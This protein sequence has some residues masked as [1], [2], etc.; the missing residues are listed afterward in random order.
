[1]SGPVRFLYKIVFRASG[2][3]ILGTLFV[4]QCIL[5][6]IVFRASGEAILGT[7]KY[8]SMHFTVKKFFAPPA[9]F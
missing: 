9:R 2:E 3:A 7:L 5:R 8:F 4:F 1:M 6:L